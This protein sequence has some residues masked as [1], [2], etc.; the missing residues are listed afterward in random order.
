M[1]LALV[2]V[3]ILFGILSAMVANR[4]RR[5]VY[6]WA[7]AGFLFGPS[8]LVVVALMD[9][10]SKAKSTVVIDSG[11]ADQRP[12]TLPSVARVPCPFCAELIIPEAKI[13]RFCNRDLVATS[14]SPS[15]QQEIDNSLT[16]DNWLTIEQTSAE[17]N[18]TDHLLLPQKPNRHEWSSDATRHC[19][20][21]TC[22]TLNEPYAIFCRH[23]GRRMPFNHVCS[24]QSSPPSIQKACPHCGAHNAGTNIYCES[25][26]A[27]I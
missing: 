13:C 24:S 26:N 27:S 3:W 25:C 14:S 23:C 5:N 7:I 15:A 2:F 10:A 11:N 1:E 17:T 9:S 18:A 19:R 20:C 16:S 12:T 4:K 8:A 21:A 22:K 6:G